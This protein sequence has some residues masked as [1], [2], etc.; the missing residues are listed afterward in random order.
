MENL[1]ISTLA[2]GAVIEAF[3]HEL[4]KVLENMLD[5]NTDPEKVRKITVTV[6]FKPN[7]KRS[8]A[9]VT[10]QA[11][12]NILPAAA[13]ETNILMG[14]DIRTGQILAEEF[15]NGQI[16]GQMSISDLQPPEPQELDKKI[17]NINN[18]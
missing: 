12:S 7:K 11:K 6:S 1:N 10:V 4:K 15:G 9:V 18:K 16:P 3:D 13:V 17:I 14:K 5:P 8:S 2:G